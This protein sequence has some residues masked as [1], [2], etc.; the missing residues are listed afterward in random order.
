ML[1]QVN[2]FKSILAIKTLYNSLVRSKLEY[3]AA[4]WA[5]HEAKYITMLERIQ[6]KFTRFL[7]LK[8]FGVYPFFPLMY[9]TLFVLGMVG[10]NKLQ[11]RREV[12]LT[13]YLFKVFRGKL[14]N[15]QILMLCAL[16]V[17]QKNGLRMRQ[18][19]LLAIPNGRTQ[20][21]SQSP[22]VCALRRLNQAHDK[23]DLFT[24]S[25][26]EFTRIILF[27]VSYS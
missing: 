21:L 24:C 25:L 17:P 7:Y 14:Y 15:P 22:L 13:T 26:S 6:N 11:V 4:V 27:I 9:P 1:R 19:Q 16:R 23:V 3:A 2:G 10:Y 12:A 20:L 18:G 8:L 5:P